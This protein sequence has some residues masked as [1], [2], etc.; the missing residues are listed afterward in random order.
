MP[1]K[2][3][4]VKFNPLAFLDVHPFVRHTVVDKIYGCIVGSAMGDTIGLY[5]EFM[6]KAQSARI[7]PDRKFQLVKPATELHPDYH[8]SEYAPSDTTSS[9][10]LCSRSSCYRIRTL[11]NLRMDRRH[12]SGAANNTVLHLQLHACPINTSESCYVRIGES[13]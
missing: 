4:Q 13:W 9:M 12:R 6:T 5:T 10:T 1:P 2:R 3:K 8:R 7:L 11:R